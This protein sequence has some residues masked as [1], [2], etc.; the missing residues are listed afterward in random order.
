MC[1]G[2]TQ[3][4]V[5]SPEIPDWLENYYKRQAAASEELYDVARDIYRNRTDYPT[6][7][8]PRIQQFTTDQ[9]GSFDLIR[10]NLGIGDLRSSREV[11]DS[12]RVVRLAE[13]VVAIP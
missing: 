1:C 10:D 6:F 8:E 2:N 13:Y 9:L 4:T 7:T 12:L 5:A 3:T 11:A